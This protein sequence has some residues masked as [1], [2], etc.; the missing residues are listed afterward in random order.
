[1]TAEEFFDWVHRPENMDRVFELEA[2]E[3]V[4]MSRPGGRHGVVCGNAG[5][6]L[7]NFTFQRRKGFVCSNDTGIVLAR[8]PDTVRGPDIALYEETLTLDEVNP[9]FLENPPTLAV[10]VLSPNDR[11]GKVTRR[12][13]EF[14]RRGVRL[15]W[16][17][18]PDAKDV[19][20]YRA[21]RDACV[22]GEDEELTGED[23]LPDL[24][25]RVADFFAMPGGR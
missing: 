12:V 23:V 1:M 10:E 5:R 2:G 13:Q 11:W 24:R 3:V 16:L 19:T 22:V 14:L 17:L 7:G 15:V 20:V 25:C 8:A 4:E 18:D 9:R 21:G 6:I